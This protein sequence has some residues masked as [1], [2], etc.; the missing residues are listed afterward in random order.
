MVG[1]LARRVAA[2]VAT[3]A[4][5]GRGKRA[6]IGLGAGPA[7]GGLVATLASRRGGNV[8][9]G[10]AA[11]N[12]AVVATGATCAH[13]HI[14][15]EL[16]R[17]PTGVALV[18]SRAVGAGRDMVGALARRVAAIVATG[19]SGGAREGAVVRLGTG[20]ARGGFVAAFAG[21]RG[22]Q[23]RRRLACSRGAGV[24]T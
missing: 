8:T 15:V 22:R 10:L 23:M 7:A 4:S 12:R 24:A 3:G 20:P 21:G 16:C 6:V 18:A 19:A 11:G 1:A 5:G 2:I 17:R 13:R 9:A 14:G